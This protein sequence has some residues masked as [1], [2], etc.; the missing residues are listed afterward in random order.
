MADLVDRG[1]RVYLLLPSPVSADYDAHRVIRRS[2]L[3]PGFRMK[4]EIPER[5][6]VEDA[7]KPI[8][9][10][11][12]RAAREAGAIVIDPMDSLCNSMACPGFTSSGEPI[13]VDP[14]HLHL[15][16]AR[17]YATFIDQTLL[18]SENGDHGSDQ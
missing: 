8:T 10:E 4:P 15:T 18:K 1:K 13:Y 5:A 16:Y 17:D 14:L 3:Q 2:I 6:A 12:R 9:T 11:L 7:I